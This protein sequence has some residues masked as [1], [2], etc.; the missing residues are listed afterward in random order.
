MNDILADID[1]SN[2]I[3]YIDRYFDRRQSIGLNCLIFL[4][5]REQTTI[6]HQLKE[7]GFTDISEQVITWIDALDEDSQILLATDIAAGLLEELVNER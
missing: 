2:I 6:A 3:A 7:W 5:L 1:R 4:S